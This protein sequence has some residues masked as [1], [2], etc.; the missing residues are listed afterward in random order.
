MTIFKMI[1]YLQNNPS[2]VNL[3]ETDFQIKVCN[4][5]VRN[6][7]SWSQSSEWLS[8][9]GNFLFSAVLKE[10]ILIPKVLFSQL[11]II[12]RDLGHIHSY[13]KS[14]GGSLA[15]HFTFWN[16]VIAV[17]FQIDIHFLLFARLYN[18]R[19][20]DRTVLNVVFNWYRDEVKYSKKTKPYRRI[21][22]WISMF[23]SQNR[24]QLNKDSL[25]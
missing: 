4:G 6:H 19:S 16:F 18:W 12:H 1:L 24:A 2:T 15:L 11:I 13:A 14:I 3:T 22:K 21:R 20:I 5:I 23:I 9:K 7:M 8:K 10:D 25:V 17:W